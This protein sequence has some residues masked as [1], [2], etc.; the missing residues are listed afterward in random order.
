MPSLPPSK[1]IL[2]KV[3]APVTKEV[4]QTVFDEN[5]ERK[6]KVVAKTVVDEECS[7]VMDEQCSTEMEY[8]CHEV[9]QEV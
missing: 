9:V 4:C 7:T 2:E 8:I 1:A 6:C 5:S 3:C